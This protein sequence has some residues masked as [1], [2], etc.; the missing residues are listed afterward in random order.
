MD[1]IRQENQLLKEENQYLNSRLEVLGN[2]NSIQPRE[3]QKIENRSTYHENP[4]LNKTGLIYE[5]YGS[6]IAVYEN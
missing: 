4:P 6:Q 1:R 2:T 3:T 5:Q